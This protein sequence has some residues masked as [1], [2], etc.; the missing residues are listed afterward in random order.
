MRLVSLRLANVRQFADP[1]RIDGIAP[2]LN[3]L[4]APN[5]HGKS[6]VFDALYAL[7]FRRHGQWDAQVRALQPYAGGQPQIGVEIE[8]DG[9]RWRVEK[10]FRRG[11]GSARLYREGRLTAQAD[12]AEAWIA[13]AMKGP[14]DGGPAGL[15]WVRQGETGLDGRD[16]KARAARRDLMTSVTREVAS[17]TGGRRLEAARRQLRQELGVLLTETGRPKT[18][19]PLRTA[20]D[21]AAALGAERDAMAERGRRLAGEIARRSALRRELAALEEPE[22][23]AARRARLSAAEAAAHEAEAHA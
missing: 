16:E 21:E 2:G 9:V 14:E 3:V 8:R 12:E 5:E 19:G 13:E 6:T 1:V 10:S 4:A 11:A 23:D 20:L 18:G 15:L 17:M 7:F 22:A